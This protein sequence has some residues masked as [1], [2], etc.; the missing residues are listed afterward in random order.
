VFSGDTRPF[1][2]LE[3]AGFDAD[4]LIHEVRVR[5]KGKVKG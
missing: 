1:S 4:I 2:A 5:V 3:S